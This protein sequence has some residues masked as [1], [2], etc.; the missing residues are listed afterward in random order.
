[1]K[2]K[3]KMKMK[4]EIEMNSLLQRKIMKKKRKIMA[5]FPTRR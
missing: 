4:M 2:M 1:M 3:M 5:I